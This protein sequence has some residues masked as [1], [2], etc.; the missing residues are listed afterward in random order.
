MITRG[1]AGK[2]S[3]SDHADRIVSDDGQEIF[4][5]LEQ[6]AIADVLV[7]GFTRTSAC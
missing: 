5:L 2:Q 1:F 4:N 6:R 3:G 7:M